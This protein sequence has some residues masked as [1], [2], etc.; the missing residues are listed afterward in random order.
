MRQ[1]D[2]SPV[3]AGVSVLYEYGLKLRCSDGLA[4]SEVRWLD[5]RLI[6]RSKRPPTHLRPRP[7]TSLLLSAMVGDSVVDDLADALNARLHSFDAHASSPSSPLR[8]DEVLAVMTGR[9]LTGGG[10][11]E[12]LVCTDEHL[13]EY[14]LSPTDT[15]PWGKTV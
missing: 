15:L 9:S 10:A 8:V 5:A 14:R 13:N 6:S 7:H 11:P 2:G 1:M 12:V 3:A 4:D